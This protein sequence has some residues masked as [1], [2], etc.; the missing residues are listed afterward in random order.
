MQ[1]KNGGEVTWAFS[2]KPEKATKAL[3]DKRMGSSSRVT[4]S[5]FYPIANMEETQAMLIDLSEVVPESD[6][7][8]VEINGQLSTEVSAAVSVEVTVEEGKFPARLRM[9]RITLTDFERKPLH[10]LGIR[11][12]HRH[13]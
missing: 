4:T 5:N 6:N 12:T 7:E 1:K 9:D 13:V 8:F 3:I 2:T 11:I 10:P